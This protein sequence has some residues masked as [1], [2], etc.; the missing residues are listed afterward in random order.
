M[1]DSKYGGW[2]DLKIQRNNVSNSLWWRD[3]KEVWSLEGWK[4]KFEYNCIWEVVNGK[5]VRLWKD[6]WVGNMTLK[7]KFPRLFSIC[8]DKESLLWQGR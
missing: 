5:D 2:S 6:K 7:E 3:M 4:D 1:L 8:S